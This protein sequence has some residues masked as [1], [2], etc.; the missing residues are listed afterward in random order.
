[1]MPLR[2]HDLPGIPWAPRLALTGLVLLIAVL[3]APRLEAG[4]E[5]TPSPPAVVLANALPA[6]PGSTAATDPLAIDPFELWMTSYYLD[7]TPDQIP[8]RIKT[9]LDFGGFAPGSPRSR[10]YARFFS[11]ALAAEPGATA[12]L[13]S[14]AEAAA[15]QE[16]AILTA[17]AAKAEHYTP[18][19]AEIPADIPLLWA[20]YRATG[21][22]K[23]LA[24]LVDLLG[25][26]GEREALATAAAASLLEAVPR[27]VNARTIA[28]E[29]F[30]AAPDK[31]KGRIA[32]I[33][34][35]LNERA[36]LAEM[37]YGRGRNYEKAKQREEAIKSYRSAMEIYP[38]FAQAYSEL[39]DIYLDAEDKGDHPKALAALQVA[40][41]YAPDDEVI[42]SRLGRAYSRLGQ[43][44]QAILWLSRAR[45]CNPKYAYAPQMMGRVAL[46]MNDTSGAIRYFQAYLALD[47]T[48]DLLSRKERNF[49]AE[50]G[51]PVTG[52]P[53][54]PLTALLLEGKYELLEGEIAVLIKE[55]RKETNGYSSVIA[56][57][58]RLTSLPGPTNSSAQ[59]VK[60]FET[61]AEQ[62]P[63]S[64]IA[65][66]ALGIVLD[67]YAWEA[68][69]G[70]WANTIIDERGKLF[71]ERLLAARQH[72]EKACALD[73]A[74]PAAPTTLIGVV[75]GLGLDREE[76][77]TQFQRAIK[78]DDTLLQPYV[79]KMTCLLPKWG[80]SAE[81]AL[82]FARSAAAAAP[83]GSPVPLVLAWAHS[84]LARHLA[85]TREDHGYYKQSGRL[86]RAQTHV[87][88]L[89]QGFPG[90]RQRPQ[91]V[92]QDC[93]PLGR[94]RR[95]PAGT[96]RPR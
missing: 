71:A 73:S 93:L 28:N 92:R 48:G 37:V 82:S 91:L 40:R 6:S 51:V 86:G 74:D 59:W 49:L 90:R 89:P 36:D 46:K 83:A 58:N 5:S 8:A 21:E 60:Q 85:N 22:K 81:E 69:G 3:P 19:V 34:T 27:H 77:E 17:L 94:F 20:E 67:K 64:P 66:A 84:E 78:A 42:L 87:R 95:C 30:R 62:R 32:P 43:Y 31:L 4:T 65:Q 88:T 15:G 11:A 52:K 57:Y 41:A 96:G 72:L 75:K 70:G 26:E 63:S 50:A 79:E 38:S 61:W 18:A 7:P 45:Q 80:G 23:S 47:P 55:K 16:K 24:A 53:S 33:V 56:A 29:L 68:R 2:R 1:M 54:T 39:A 12:G 44:D 35:R 9:V 76:M 25:A 13:K 10:E 14:A